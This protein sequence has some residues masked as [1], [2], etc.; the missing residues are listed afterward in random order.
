MNNISFQGRTNI[1]FDKSLYNQL[2]NNSKRQR[3]TNLNICKSNICNINNCKNIT[4]DPN[5]KLH[6]GVLLIHEKGGKFFH[7]A[8]NQIDEIIDCIKDFQMIA[9]RNLTAWIIGGIRNEKTTRDVNKLAEILCD[10]TDIDTSI[11]AGQKT[12]APNITIYSRLD[13]LQLNI[14]SPAPKK[15]ENVENYLEKYFDIVE[16]NNTSSIA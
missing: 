8:Q 16:L 9:K 5:E 10:R 14:G 12:I 11:I 2:I 4:Y 15:S 13:E 1:T 6:P 7:D 3:Y